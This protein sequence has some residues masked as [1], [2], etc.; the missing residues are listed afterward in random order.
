MYTIKQVP[1]DFIVEEISDHEIIDNGSYYIFLMTKKNT[2]TLDAIHEISRTL[3]IPMKFIGFA[4]SKD[5]VAITK[6]YIS[7]KKMKKVED[8]VE[9]DN[10]KMESIGESKDPI[11]LGDLVGNKFIIVLRD[12]KKSPN[13]ITRFVNY[14]GPQRF[15]RN[16]VDIGKAIIKKDFKGAVELILETDG[17]ESAQIKEH[18]LNSPNDHVNALRKVNRKLLMLYVHSYQSF[19]WNKT[20]KRYSGNDENISIP[21][22]GAT[23]DM[24][25][26][27]DI[28]EILDEENIGQRDF[29][30]R[31]IPELSTVGEERNLYCEIEDLE[32]SEEMDDELN[33]GSKKV[34]VSF[35]LKKSSYA[36][37]CIE[38]MFR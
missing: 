25:S 38:E 22:V 6:Q 36:T 37:V 23:T 12:I 1:E 32:I 11:F 30:I 16:N 28:K 14:F 2:N 9:L 7:I 19:I 13:R 3:R 15:S 29:I 33:K 26:F 31:E 20:A 21:I 5:K 35:R 34:V 4:G 17:K 18:L 27:P 8:L 10:I 24:F